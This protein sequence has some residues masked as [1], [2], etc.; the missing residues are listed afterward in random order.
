MGRLKWGK[1]CQ[2][3]KRREKAGSECAYVCECAGREG[4]ELWF[5][6]VTVYTKW[7]IMSAK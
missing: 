5:W 4:A 3:F 7:H 6:F 1:L 2:L